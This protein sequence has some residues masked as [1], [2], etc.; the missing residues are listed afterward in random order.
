MAILSFN[1]SLSPSSSFDSSGSS[2]SGETSPYHGSQH[3][4]DA[5]PSSS[6]GLIYHHRPNAFYNDGIVS[7]PIVVVGSSLPSNPSCS[8]DFCEKHVKTRWKA[9]TAIPVCVVKSVKN[10]SNLVVAIFSNIMH[11]CTLTLHNDDLM[12]INRKVV[13]ATSR[14]LTEPYLCAMKILNPHA[15]GFT[16]LESTGSETLTPENAQKLGFGSKIITTINEKVDSLYNSENRFVKHVVSRICAASMIL[17][18]IARVV[19]L[20]LGLICAAL[21]I[22]T[23]GMIEGL[24]KRA[25]IGLASGPAMISDMLIT[26]QCVINPKV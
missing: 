8:G 10:I 4:Y 24:N 15:K 6:S 7:A 18:V 16:V 23:L 13:K 14:L 5:N 11:I 26:I 22:V 1:P 17:S 25:L 21:S 9:L 3:D 20:A 19:D 2:E 12:D